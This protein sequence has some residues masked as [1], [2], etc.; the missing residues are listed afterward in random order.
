MKIIL[1]RLVHL[2][3]IGVVFAL[4]LLTPTILAIEL[5]DGSNH[6]ANPPRLIGATTSQSGAY[7]WTATYYFT[8]QI[9]EDAGEPLQKL[10]IAPLHSSDRPLFTIT[11]P[12][13]FAGT[14]RQP[15][16]VLALRTVTLDPQTQIFSI[17]FDPP[18]TPGQTVTV[19]LN[20]V[21]N[22]NTGGT[23]LYGVTAFPPGAQP[24]SQFL[25][26]GRI[27]IDDR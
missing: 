2:T 16:P 25:G 15:G 13:A 3:P 8:I 7:L 14:V 9:P 27:R 5:R 17:S 22:P 4:A 6:F 23:Y 26:F 1:D 19:Q 12:T 21:R 20:P 11:K 10:T 24:A 18:V